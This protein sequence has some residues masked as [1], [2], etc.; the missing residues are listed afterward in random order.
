MTLLRG[1][2]AYITIYS[3][4]TA[5]GMLLL[6]NRVNVKDCTCDYKICKPCIK[7]HVGITTSRRWRYCN[8]IADMHYNFDPPCA[9][10]V[11]RGEPEK[12]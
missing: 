11:Y 1:S 5:L 9:Q 6:S 10:R 8:E 2:L 7:K 3:I 12:L 4:T